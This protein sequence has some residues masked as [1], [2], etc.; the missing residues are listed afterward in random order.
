MVLRDASSSA[1]N[2]PFA[3]NTTWKT[4]EIFVHCSSGDSSACLSINV[5]PALTN[6]TLCFLP[7]FSV[8]LNVMDILCGNVPPLNFSSLDEFSNRTPASSNCSIADFEVADVF[9]VRAADFVFGIITLLNFCRD[10]GPVGN[11]LSPIL[12]KSFFVPKNYLGIK[13]NVKPHAEGSRNALKNIQGM[14]AVIGI[15]KASN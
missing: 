13:A 7:S 1:G 6:T 9:F 5:H 10:H 2:A 4:H 8:I 3:F 14:T 12:A 15:F 11:A